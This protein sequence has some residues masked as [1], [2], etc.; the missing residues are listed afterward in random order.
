MYGTYIR[1]PKESPAEVMKGQTFLVGADVT[2]NVLDVW[3]G[4]ESRRSE[5]LDCWEFLAQEMS[6]ATVHGVERLQELVEKNALGPEETQ[7]SLG[8]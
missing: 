3:N 7:K 6:T 5:D 8:Q 4:E 2:I 1:I